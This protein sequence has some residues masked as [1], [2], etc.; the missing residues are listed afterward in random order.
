MDELL[1]LSRAVR[2]VGKYPYA[3]CCVHIDNEKAVR[4]CQDALRAGDIRSVEIERDG[5]RV[6]LKAQVHA[7][8][9]STKF[10]PCSIQL[11]GGTVGFPTCTCKATYV[12]SAA[13][14]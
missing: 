12:D 2:E 10:Y 1:Q 9:T 4:L 8:Q 13:L 14:N 5:S 7:S 3:A 6:V 11:S